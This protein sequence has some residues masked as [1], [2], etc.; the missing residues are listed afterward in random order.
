MRSG[1]RVASSHSA[2]EQREAFGHTFPQPKRLRRQTHQGLRSTEVTWVGP[3]ERVETS[4]WRNTTAALAREHNVRHDSTAQVENLLHNG[5]GI[6]HKESLRA[7]SHTRHASVR[8]SHPE[9]ARQPRL[10]LPFNANNIAAEVVDAEHGAVTEPFSESSQDILD[11]MKAN[12]HILAEQRFGCLL[13]HLPASKASAFA[14][15]F[16]SQC[17]SLPY[18]TVRRPS[19]AL[20]ERL[21][22]CCSLHLHKGNTC[23]CTTT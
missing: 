2:R 16:A 17:L 22:A 12:E 15:T 4:S 19:V 21:C 5:H 11:G 14:C 7:A 3:T 1:R 8:C 18:L 6:G 10:G 23:M 9:G 13:G 20:L